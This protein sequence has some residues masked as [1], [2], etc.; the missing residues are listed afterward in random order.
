MLGMDISQFAQWS[1]DLVQ[2]W[3]YFGLLVV[4]IICT[5]TIFFPLPNYI[6]VFLFG[7]ILNPLLVALFSAIGAA[8]GESVSYGVGRGGRQI[9]NNKE[10][11]YYTLAKAWFEKKR[12]FLIVVI[13]AATP[14]PFDIVGLVGGSIKYNFKKFVLAAFIGKLIGFLILALGGYYGVEMVLNFFELNF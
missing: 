10:R 14:L 3:G 5:G 4:N 11:R 6:L 13:F 12:G 7:G 1:Y 8:I 9:L 2:N